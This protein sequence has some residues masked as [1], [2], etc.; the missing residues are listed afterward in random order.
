MQIPGGTDPIP[1]C[2]HR[3]RGRVRKTEYY[4][5]IGFTGEMESPSLEPSEV[6]EEDSHESRDVFGSFVGGTL[7][8]SVSYA[9]CESYSIR[10]PQPLRTQRRR[11]R[12]PQAGRRRRCS[13][14]HSSRTGLSLSPW[15]L[16]PCKALSTYQPGSM[17]NTSTCCGEQP[18]A[19]LVP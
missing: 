14:D 12:L 11:S 3:G 17:S 18:R 10:A 1:S 5:A 9:T 2:Q 4:Y 16:S 6:L 8:S 15:S 13:L 7:L 19:H